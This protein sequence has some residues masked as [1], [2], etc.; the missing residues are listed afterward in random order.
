VT[1][2]ASLV[3]A[4]LPG[5]SFVTILDYF[6]EENEHHFGLFIISWSVRFPLL[7]FSVST[8]N[9]TRGGLLRHFTFEAVNLTALA[10]VPP[11]YYFEI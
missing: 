8:G 2:F 1:S 11:P 4:P 3:K 6:N 9:Q 7:F 10:I 5:H